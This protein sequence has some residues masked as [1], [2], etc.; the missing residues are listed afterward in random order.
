[1]TSTG[2]KIRPFPGMQAD[3]AGGRAGLHRGLRLRLQPAHRRGHRSANAAVD[4][5]PGTG[6]GL[7]SSGKI[8]G[9][10]PD[11]DGFLIDL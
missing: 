8:Q 10:R 3:A 11:F 6:G 2:S 1:M 4:A 5:A 7:G 9:W